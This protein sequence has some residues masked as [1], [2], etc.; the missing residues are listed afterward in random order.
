M[1]V[2]RYMDLRYPEKKVP[3]PFSHMQRIIAHYTL[4][5]YFFKVEQNLATGVFRLINTKKTQKVQKFGLEIQ[6]LSL[7]SFS[8]FLTICPI[9]FCNLSIETGPVLYNR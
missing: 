9:S 3:A 5:K 8:G 4:E 2:A 1:A 7:Y 6:L